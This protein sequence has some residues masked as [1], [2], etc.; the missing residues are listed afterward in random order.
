MRIAIVG[1]GISGLYA[2]HRLHPDHEITVFEAND[3]VGG[4]T[5]THEILAGGKT[6]SIDTGFIVFNERNYP[7][8]SA[9]LQELEVASQE[10][11]M[12][13]SV[14]D[15]RSGLEYCGTSLNTLFAQRS[16][17]L[18]P[19]YWNMIRGIFRF[20]R[21]GL[22]AIR[23]GNP[24]GSLRAFLTAHRIPEST[25]EQYVIPMVSAIWSADPE[26]LLNYPASFLLR[27]FD[28]HGMLTINDRP[29]WRVVRGGSQSYVRKLIEPF[30]DRIR[31]N[32]PVYNVQRCID[33]VRVYSGDGEGDVFD[34]VILAVHSNQALRMLAEPTRD[35]A[36]ILSAIP[37]QRN[38]AVL[39]TDDRLMPRS[40]R[41]WAAWNYHI[42]PELQTETAVTYNM[43]VLQGL[44]DAPETFLVTLNRTET[45]DPARVIRRLVYHHPVF[46]PDAVAAQA[47]HH[48]ISG[49]DRIHY[50]GAYWGYG[51]HED[52]IRSAEAVLAS[53]R[54]EAIHA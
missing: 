48:E 29:Q 40:R 17:L 51:F 47:R 19:G 31:L 20:N 14:R 27:F 50:C 8:F 10:T 46:T 35:E 28:N 21:V 4:H 2:A 53:F 24:T 16:N 26:Q 39:H 43:N 44:E 30:A 3:Y 9:L 12:S 54:N 41:A 37:Y 18:R 25:V 36:A 11:S 42:T 49:V 23:S 32:A 34:E 33:G 38:E 6:W 45:I 13:F 15:E 22:E 1:S 5:H 7:R 52:G